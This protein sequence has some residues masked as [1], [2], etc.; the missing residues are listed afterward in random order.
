MHHANEGE[1]KNYRRNPMANTRFHAP[2]GG[3]V[4]N[5]W[6]CSSLLR[7]MRLTRTE[8]NTYLEDG[9]STLQKGGNRAR[10][11]TFA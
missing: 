11:Y 6:Q 5:F 7:G 1:E 9:I 8:W 4:S 3:G 2:T 10:V